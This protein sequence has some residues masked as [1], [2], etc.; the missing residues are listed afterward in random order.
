MGGLQKGEEAIKQLE[1]ALSISPDAHDAM[2]EI[3]TIYK[4]QI[5][6][7]DKALAWGNKYL[8]AKGGTLADSDPMKIQLDNI[9]MEIEGAK[10]AAEDGRDEAEEVAAAAAEEATSTEESAPTEGSETPQAEGEP[11]A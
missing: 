8:E 3:T 11:G 4:F 2:A 9:N 10:M 5:A 6:D 1:K 7:L